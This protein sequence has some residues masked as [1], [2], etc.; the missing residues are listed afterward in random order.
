MNWDGRGAKVLVIDG[1]AHI[2]RLIT[3][4]LRA[5]AVT[6]VDE[7]RNAAAA[8]PLIRRHAPDLIIADWSTDSTDLVLFAH[9]LRRGEFGDPRIP[10]LATAVST[11]HAILAR[12]MEA[13]ID[14]VIAKPLSAIDVIH[15]AGALIYERRAGAALME[16]AQ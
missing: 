5:L 11:H 8:V 7:A 14:D 15:R 9:R 16:A 1:S 10:I 12:A 4:L 6:D 3:T 13:G 2:R